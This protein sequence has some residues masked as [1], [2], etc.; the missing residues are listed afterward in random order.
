MAFHENLR[1]L[2]LAKGMTQPQLAELAQIEQSYLSKLENGRSSPSDEVLKRLADALATPAE[3]LLRNGDD[4]PDASGRRRAALAAA[5]VVVLAIGGIGGWSAHDLWR[6]RAAGV[7][8]PDRAFGSLTERL[9]SAAPS[10]VKLDTVDIG[11]DGH[12]M[13]SGRTVDRQAVADYLGELRRGGI[14]EAD[15]LMLSDSDTRFQLSIQQFA[16]APMPSD[17]Q[18][19]ASAAE[20]TRVMAR[21]EQA[22]LVVERMERAPNGGYYAQGK[23]DDVA[24]A[25]AAVDALAHEGY[26]FTSQRVEGDARS[27]RFELSFFAPSSATK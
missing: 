23:A 18:R 4:A 11:D 26:A 13:L 1:V 7:G 2:R 27:A 5:A 3:E 15:H 9:H 6:A 21:F 20:H 8:A 10:G 16:P 25:Q 14:G 24:K 22:G 12:I 17:Q 19:A